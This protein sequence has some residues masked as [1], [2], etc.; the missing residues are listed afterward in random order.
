V[1]LRRGAR[2]E[3]HIILAQRRKETGKPVQALNHSRV[4]EVKF[5]IVAALLP[6]AKATGPENPTLFVS[7]FHAVRHRYIRH[8]RGTPR[9]H[10]DRH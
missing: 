4:G 8:K 1:A 10:D 7:M 6:E 3:L 5:L 2:L 9:F